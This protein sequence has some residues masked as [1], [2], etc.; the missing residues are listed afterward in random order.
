[1]LKEAWRVQDTIIQEQ[2]SLLVDSE[3]KVNCL[4]GM[5]Q[6]LKAKICCCQ[7]HLLSPTPHYVKGE[8]PVAEDL[9]LEYKTEEESLDMSH[10][11]PPVAGCSPSSKA[12]SRSLTLEDL[13][14]E[15]NGQICHCF[16]HL[17]TA[18]TQLNFFK[19][20]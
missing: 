15:N 12:P 4:I 9:E 13:D 17:V 3:L 5:F 20:F 6:D 10:H 14:P 16:C 11:T 1:M 2:Q 19:L 18:W 8:G 7:D